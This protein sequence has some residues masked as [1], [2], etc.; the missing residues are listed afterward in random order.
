MSQEITWSQFLENFKN[1][2]EVPPTKSQIATKNQQILEDILKNSLKFYFIF[3]Y[4]Y[5]QSHY[6]ILA[7]GSQTTFLSN[8]IGFNTASGLEHFFKNHPKL[9]YRLFNTYAYSHSVSLTQSQ[10]LIAQNYGGGL[11]LSFIFL[12]KKTYRLRNYLGIALEEGLLFIDTIKQATI[13][14]R[15]KKTFFQAPFRFGLIMDFIG[16]LSLQLGLEVPLV[17]KITYAHNNHRQDFTQLYNINF[18]LIASF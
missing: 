14:H 17:R 16:Y 1:K 11:D 4:T 5:S 18:S 10:I 12:N 13:T 7:Q 8:N 3:G 2:N 9:G 6:S 15:N